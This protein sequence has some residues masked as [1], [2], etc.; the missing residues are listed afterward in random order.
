[1]Y[2]TCPPQI[3]CNSMKEGLCLSHLLF[4]YPH[5]CKSVEHIKNTKHIYVAQMNI[6]YL[7]SSSMPNSK[8]WRL[9]CWIIQTLLLFSPSSSLI[10]FPLHSFSYASLSLSLSFTLP[11]F[12]PPLLRRFLLLR[13]ILHSRICFSK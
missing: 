12:L 8:M 3:K 4:F 5:A 1:M 11:S 6:N 13:C 7:T 9:W 10:S 2:I